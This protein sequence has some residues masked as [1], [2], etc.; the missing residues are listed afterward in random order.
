MKRS[1]PPLLFAIV[2]CISGIQ[3]VYALS[4]TVWGNLKP[5]SHAA[6]FKVIFEYDTSRPYKR[7]HDYL[8]NPLKAD[9][10]R[11]IQINVWY[12]AASTGTPLTI[13][14]YLYLTA[15]E[16]NS[17]EPTEEQKKAAI[18]SFKNRFAREADEQ[19][20][21]QIMDAKTAAIRDAKP[22]AGKFPLVLIAPST[23][24]ASPVSNAILS[25]YL[26]TRGFV[27]AS[28]PAIGLS[29]KQLGFDPLGTM[30]QMQD[31]QFIIA[32]L[33]TDP[34]VDPDK[35]ALVGFSFGG[36]PTSL[37]AMHN[38]EV[39]ALV[40][41]ETA[42]ANKYGYS[43]LFQNPLYEPRLL[44]APFLHFTA[45]ET[46]E[47]SDDAFVRSL[48][49]SKVHI[50]KLKG[51]RPASFSSYV[52]YTALLP[53]Q[54]AMPDQ[55]AQ[56]SPAESKAGY[57]TI[58]AYT[59]EFLNAYVNKNQQSMDFFI[60]KPEENGIPAGLALAEVR[61]GLKTPPAEEDFIKIIHEKGL[62]AAVAVYQEVAKN[63]PEYVIFNDTTLIEMAHSLI[64]QKKTK[65]AIEM[66]N[67][68][69]EA[70]PTTYETFELLGNIYM[71]EGNKQ[72][73]IDNFNRVIEIDP[74]NQNAAEILKKLNP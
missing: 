31:L 7:K 73:A 63:D 67:L 55:P 11:P 25:E 30:T 22:A 15:R 26:A 8:G 20:V 5:G 9:R 69:A 6:G 14:D 13:R 66:L 60:R 21:Q 54:P 46:N 65:E 4:S 47:A 41:L 10:R 32:K 3:R 51:M 48:K 56:P 58:C 64:E 1:V 23:G 44:T 29:T 16:E 18:S 19:A 17:A 57:E 28:S 27:V 39:D 42:A 52:M 38:P 50:V 61:P 72:L 2:L 12:P 35:L 37:I 74:N 59:A 71:N 68:N 24:L 70:H 49:Y 53:T 43:V 62:P 36:L 40:S 33:R 34:A 45:M